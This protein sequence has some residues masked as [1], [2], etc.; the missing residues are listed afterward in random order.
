MAA[1]T[2]HFVHDPYKCEKLNQVSL[3]FLIEKK[4][5]ALS[6]LQVDVPKF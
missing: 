6:L 3:V 1:W 5:Y 4:L 2:V